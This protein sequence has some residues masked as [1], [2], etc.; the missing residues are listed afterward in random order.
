M[1]FRNIKKNARV[2]SRVLFYIGLFYAFVC[3]V[4]FTKLKKSGEFDNVMFATIFS[5]LISF[6]FLP[7]ILIEYK[8][9]PCFSCLRK[10][11]PSKTDNLIGIVLLEISPFFISAGIIMFS[12][13]NT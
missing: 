8:N 12:L 1:K 10:Y 13:M 4:N 11:S 5:G 6:F 3:L 7:A 2:S 9:N